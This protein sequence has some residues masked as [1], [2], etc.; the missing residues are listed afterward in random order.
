MEQKLRGD[1]LGG[2]DE[3]VPMRPAASYSLRDV[4]AHVMGQTPE[5]NQSQSDATIRELKQTVASSRKQVGGV[6]QT[7]HSSSASNR[8]VAGSHQIRRGAPAL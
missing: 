2:L 5:Q 7:I 3:I 6:T 8:D 4:A 1:L